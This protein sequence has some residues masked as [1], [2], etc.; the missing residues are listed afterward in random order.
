MRR[1]LVRAIV[2]AGLALGVMPAGMWAAPPP[3][4]HRTGPRPHPANRKALPPTAPRAPMTGAG[5]PPPLGAPGPPP[6]GAAGPPP[7]GAAGPPPLGAIGAQPR[8][9]DRP[10]PIAP[11][12]RCVGDACA[13]AMAPAESGDGGFVGAGAPDGFVDDTGDLAPGE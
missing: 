3:V 9:V 10:A 2:L 5:G 8:I 4:H 7:L 12:A 11:G 1:D 13:G 6:L